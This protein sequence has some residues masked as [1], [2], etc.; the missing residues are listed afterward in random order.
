MATI[1]PLQ[2]YKCLFLAGFKELAKEA[3]QKFRDAGCAESDIRQALLN[4]ISKDELDIPAEQEKETDE[5]T[6][7]ADAIDAWFRFLS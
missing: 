1:W 7:F 4:H 3:E 5:V 2:S 6:C